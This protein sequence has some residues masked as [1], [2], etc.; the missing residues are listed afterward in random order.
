MCRWQ[1]MR[2]RLLSRLMTPVFTGLV[3]SIVQMVKNLPLRF[4]VARW[5]FGLLTMLYVEL[6]VL[7][8]ILPM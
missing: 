8:V 7:E 5:L 2:V 4:I 3:V 1:R 6:L